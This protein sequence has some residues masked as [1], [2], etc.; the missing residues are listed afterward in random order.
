MNCTG[1][2]P[3]CLDGS[4]VTSVSVEQF[5]GIHWEEAMKAETLKDNSIINWSKST[6]RASQ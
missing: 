2:M 4:T 6:E 5:D 3:H 1:V